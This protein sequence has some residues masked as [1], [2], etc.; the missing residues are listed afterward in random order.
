M[1]RDQRPGNRQSCLFPG[2]VLIFWCQSDHVGGCF[3]ACILEIPDLARDLEREVKRGA[4]AF[5]A[6]RPHFSAVAVDD[7][8]D[9][10]QP[11]AEAGE[12]IRGVQTLEDAK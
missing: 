9:G 7:A 3:C 5:D 10:C 8:L 11:G 1:A 6:L 2:L 4:F 12:L